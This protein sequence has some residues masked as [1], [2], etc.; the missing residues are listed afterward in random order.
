MD[1][2]KLVARNAIWLWIMPKRCTATL[3]NI[4]SESQDGEIWRTI[5][6]QS[7]RHSPIRGIGSICVKCVVKHIHNLVICG[8]IYDSTRVS[9][10][11]C[12]KFS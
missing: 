9:F 2:W 3:K 5:L 7:L 4:M 12:L 1:A 6:C 10:I 8:S 11:P